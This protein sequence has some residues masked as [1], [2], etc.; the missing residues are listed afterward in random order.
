MKIKK[1]I[2]YWGALF[3]AATLLWGCGGDDSPPDAEVFPRENKY[4]NL[5]GQVGGVIL[6]FG[7]SIYQTGATNCAFGKSFCLSSRTTLTSPEQ[8]QAFVTQSPG[9][10]DSK[11][12]VLAAGNAIDFSKNQ[13][14]ALKLGFH[15]NADVALKIQELENSIEIQPVIC[16]TVIVGDAIPRLTDIFV[17]VPRDMPDKPVVFID[18]GTIRFG[19]ECSFAEMVLRS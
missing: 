12:S 14:W 8:F 5:S 19:P 17:V 1:F 2:L 6:K 11:A 18:H 9:D 4:E 13:L 15:F 7:L 10:D 3:V 16:H